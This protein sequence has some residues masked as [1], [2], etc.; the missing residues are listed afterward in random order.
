[1]VNRLA[2]AQSTVAIW[3]WQPAAIVT[4]AT[5]AALTALTADAPSETGTS[6]ATHRGDG[7]ARC[8]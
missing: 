5:V 4:L 7:A 8:R 3:H 2:T 1:M 6:R